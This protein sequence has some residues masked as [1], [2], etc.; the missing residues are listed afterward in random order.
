[1]WYLDFYFHDFDD[2]DGTFGVC[3]CSTAGK[4][5]NGIK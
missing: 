5:T 3:I 1:M 4:F 2:L